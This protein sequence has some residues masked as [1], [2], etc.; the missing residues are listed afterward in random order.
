MRQVLHQ[1]WA[2]FISNMLIIYM[3][4]IHASNSK[5]KMF[6]RLGWTMRTC[7]TF[8]RM[9]HHASMNCV[10]YMSTTTLLPFN[11]KK[12]PWFCSIMKHNLKVLIDDKLHQNIASK[13]FFLNLLL[14]ISNIFGLQYFLQNHNHFKKIDN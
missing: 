10:P 7:G 12:N 3:I 13:K 1:F 9:T 6:L 5:I 14:F 11:M 8:K 4:M 2:M